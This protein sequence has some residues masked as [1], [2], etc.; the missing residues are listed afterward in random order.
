MTLLLSMEDRRRCRSALAR[1]A[2]FSSLSRS[3]M[4]RISLCSASA[5][6]PWTAALRLSARTTCRATFRTVSC[7]MSFTCKEAHSLITK[8]RPLSRLGGKHSIILRSI[9]AL[10]MTNGWPRNSSVGK[11]PRAGAG[12]ALPKSPLRSPER[13]EPCRMEDQTAA[14]R[15]G[16][17]G[18]TGASAAG[19]STG[20]SRRRP[21]VRSET[22]PSKALSRVA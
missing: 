9:S 1:E 4:R 15:A 11:L 21:T 22:Q 7:A 17:I 3:A 14:E 10:K 16:S 6:W 5:D 20:M 13:F 18:R 2:K 19:N 8:Y 12:E